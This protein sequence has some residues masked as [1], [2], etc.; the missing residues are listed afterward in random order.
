MRQYGALLL[1]VAYLA[2]PVALVMVARY[3]LPCWA[4]T[5]NVIPSSRFGECTGLGQ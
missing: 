4:L 2:A 3:Y 1:V 5:L